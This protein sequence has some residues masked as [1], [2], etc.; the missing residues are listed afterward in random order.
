[1][2]ATEA[3]AAGGR[4]IRSAGAW[5]APITGFR[6][7]G[8]VLVVVGHAFLASRIFPFTGVIHVIGLIIP[9]FF[10]VS[11]YALYR[12]FML[13]DVSGEPRPPA[14]LFWWRR[15]L[16]IYPL[17]AVAL[18]L[19]LIFLPGV[20]PHGGS[21]VEYFELYAFLQVYDKH[22]VVFSGI[23]AA[24]FLCDEVAF[25]LFLPGIA[26]LA[27]RIAARWR[28]STPQRRLHAHVVVALAMI[29]IGM[30]ARTWLVL[31]KVPG[32]TSLP[33]SNLDYYGFGIL[34]AAATIAERQGQR[35]PGVVQRLR[36]HPGLAIFTL[37]AGS[38]AMDFVARHPGEVFSP[39]EDVS[40]Y[41]LY[42]IMVVP[43]MTVMVLGAQDTPF[44][45]RLGSKRFG[46]AATLSLHIYIWHQLVLA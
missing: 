46:W 40:R 8:A 5:C 27:H 39:F 16:R 41:A 43:L 44:N 18:T 31:A 29:V 3:P 26:A 6:A 33:L 42:T 32:A 21:I 11:A 23:P 12:P 7:V 37:L 10:V 19:Y 25:Y 17:F 38:V 9:V 28:A 24:W 20:R 15:F 45:A 1:M 22:L 2:T 13:A 36:D 4:T 30:V 34:L 35:L 14:R